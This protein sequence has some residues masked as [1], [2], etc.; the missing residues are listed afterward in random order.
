[1]PVSIISSVPMNCIE[2]GRGQWGERRQA[3]IGI[4]GVSEI[5]RDLLQAM[6]DEV[7][8]TCCKVHRLD[9]SLKYMNVKDCLWCITNFNASGHRI[10]QSHHNYGRFNWG[11]GSDPPTSASKCLGSGVSIAIKA[12]TSCICHHLVQLESIHCGCMPC[13]HP[14]L[15]SLL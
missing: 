7:A 12:T 1:M 9:F 14:A 5:V 2:P 11:S 10:T 3:H 4:C 13:L 6:P 8:D 15:W